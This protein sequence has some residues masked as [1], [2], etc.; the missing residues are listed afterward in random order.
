LKTIHEKRMQMEE[1]GK[2]TLNDIRKL[3]KGKT[4]RSRLQQAV[5]SVILKLKTDGYSYDEFAAIGALV[6]MF[7][8]VYDKEEE[9]DEEG[10]EKELNVQ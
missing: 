3:L 1:A 9:E 4:D 8:L 5:S 2:H 7:G 6:A 10:E